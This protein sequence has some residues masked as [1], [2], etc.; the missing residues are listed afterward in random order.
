MVRAG[1]DEGVH[2]KGGI[3]EPFDSEARLG[4]G[5]GLVENEERREREQ[6][7]PEGGKDDS[8]LVAQTVGVA[9]AA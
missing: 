8:V 4:M 2:F 6:G 1:G 3:V 7:E 5:C 9:P